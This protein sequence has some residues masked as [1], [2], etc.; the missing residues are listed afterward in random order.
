MLYVGRLS[1]RKNILSIIKAL[2]YVVEKKG[3]KSVRLVLVGK[4]ITQ[5]D[6]L[7]VETLKE[8]IFSNN[9]TDRVVFAGFCPLQ[10]LAS[11]YKDC[12]LHVNFSRTGSMDKT[13]MEA[14]ACGCPVLTDNEA[15][16]PELKRHSLFESF[17]EKGSLE[18]I[19]N[20]I[21][22]FYTHQQTIDRTRYFKVVDKSHTLAGYA[23]KIYSIL[24]S[25]NEKNTINH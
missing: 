23:D 8:Y 24:Q 5:E 25:L 7:Y 3:M 15:V 17:L 6:E 16:I 14:L 9:L 10:E 11:F 18:E 22:Y 19:G 1:E 2:Q 12:F 4:P 21:F 20:R 13:I